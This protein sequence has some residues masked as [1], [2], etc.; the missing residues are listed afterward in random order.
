[1]SGHGGRR[2][3][4]LGRPK[5]STNKKSKAIREQAI[6]TGRTPLEVMIEAMRYYEAQGNRDRA[7][8]IA[9]DAAPYM[10]PRLNSTDIGNKVGEAFKQ[11][12]TVIIL[13]HNGRD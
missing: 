2:P 5:G 3:N 8:A 6:A 10:H 11:E 7:S 13:P 4:Q 12:Q 9:K 1:M